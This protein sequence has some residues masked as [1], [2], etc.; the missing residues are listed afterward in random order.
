MGLNQQPTEQRK[1][2]TDAKLIPAGYEQ[3]DPTGVK[4]LAPPTGARVCIIQTI[5]QNIRWRD[6]GTDPTTTTGMQLLATRDFLYTGDLVAIRFLE[7]T[8][9]AQINVSYY[10]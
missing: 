9:G 3:I 5:T 6:D 10:F 7:E 4:G 2:T 8:A 1:Y